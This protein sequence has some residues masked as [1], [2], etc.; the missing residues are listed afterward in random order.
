MG[1]GEASIIAVSI[2]QN[3]SLVATDNKQ[4]RKAAQINNIHLIG[5]IEIIISLYQQKKISLEKA[6]LSLQIL[7]QE[8]WFNPYLIEKAMEDLK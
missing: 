3:D 2:G 7:K 5:S 8:G 4:G 1:K 6:K